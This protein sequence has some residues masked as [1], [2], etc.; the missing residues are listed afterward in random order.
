MNN[1]KMFCI[2]DEKL[3]TNLACDFIYG[4]SESNYVSIQSYGVPYI[5][6]Q[7]YIQPRCCHCIN[8]LVMFL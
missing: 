1:F 2:V 3:S 4:N 8:R 7:Q 5:D 6:R